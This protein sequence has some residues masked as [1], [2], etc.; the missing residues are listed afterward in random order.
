GDQENVSIYATSTFEVP[1]ETEA[2]LRIGSDDWVKVWLNGEPVHEFA[3]FRGVTLDQDQIPVTL[4][5]GT[6][7]ILLRINQGVLGYGFV[8]RLTDRAGE[9]IQVE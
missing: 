9:P 5:K 7:S 8:V 1:E 2:T 4:K 3:S 6:N